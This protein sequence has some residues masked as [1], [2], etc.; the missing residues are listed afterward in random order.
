MLLAPFLLYFCESLAWKEIDVPSEEEIDYRLHELFINETPRPCNAY[1]NG[2]VHGLQWLL[3]MALGS[4]GK[5]ST[6]A[7]GA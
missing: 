7:M 2:R 6:E 3:G 5:Y 4:L 1:D